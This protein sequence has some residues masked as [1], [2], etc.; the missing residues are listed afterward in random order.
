MS[1]TVSF[2]MGFHVGNSESK[3]QSNRV[4]RS[5]LVHQNAVDMDEILGILGIFGLSNV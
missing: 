2:F 4:I 1:L 5:I 3:V